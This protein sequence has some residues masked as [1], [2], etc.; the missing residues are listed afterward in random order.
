[1]F[2]FYFFGV[3]ILSFSSLFFL[4]LQEKFDTLKQAKKFERRMGD[5]DRVSLTLRFENCTNSF[6]SSLTG[7]TVVE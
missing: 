7:L 2:F 4:S 3:K 6:R 5:E 1:M